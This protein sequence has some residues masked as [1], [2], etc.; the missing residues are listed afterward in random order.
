[1]D[2]AALPPLR[3]VVNPGNGCAGP[4]VDALEAH[5]PFEL[6]RIQ[7]SPDGDFPNGVPNPLLPERREATALA[8]RKSHADLGVAWDGDFDR[9]F[10]FDGEGRFVEGY[11]VIG[12][13]A[14]AALRKA[15]G[16]RVI[17]DPR[18]TWNTVE[19][20]HEL[21]GSP[22]QSRT[23]HAYL[24][25]RMRRED[26]AYGGEM[27][28]H[29][30]FRDFAYCDS[31]MIP[32]LLVAELMGRSGKS[33]AQLVNEAVRRFPV[34]GEINRHVAD[35]DAALAA[36]ESAYAPDA[37]SVDYTDG[38]SVEYADWRFNVRMSNTEPLIRLNVEARGDR[39]LME[40]RTD[41]LL[42]RLDTLAVAV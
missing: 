15:P 23:G 21:G 8:V 4:V 40:R 19:V 17:H 33:L 24:K 18:L 9:C 37:R 7:H 25:E 39:E 42:R 16:S 28:G 11:Y 10:F 14:E 22:V 6:V 30:Y 27:S 13:L 26:A 31:G 29:H 34:S 35:P 36:L 5:L 41:E 2:V 1:V 32:W 20:C 3:V 12:L 38:L